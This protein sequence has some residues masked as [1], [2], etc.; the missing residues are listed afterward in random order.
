[1]RKII[2]AA[3]ILFLLVA[4]V[5]CQKERTA[6]T[7]ETTSQEAQQTSNES[8]ENSFTS[9]SSEVLVSDNSSSPSN[10]ETTEENVTS[11]SVE[12]QSQHS[13][14]VDGEQYDVEFYDNQT[15]IELLTMLPLDITMNDL[16]S[17]EKFYYLN[18][19]LTTDPQNVRQIS[20]G[21]LMLYGSNCLVLFYENFS[22]SY[23]YTPV[24]RVIN[25]EQLASLSS[26][27]S[28]GVQLN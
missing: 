20:R 15:V 25:P 26:V 27:N 1:M 22:T 7:V 28:V 2:G 18:Q 17:N 13:I 23:S 9:Q 12:N 4:L 16:N 24:G 3:S 21:D 10:E 14:T 19:N 5:A 11:P 6:E 8:P